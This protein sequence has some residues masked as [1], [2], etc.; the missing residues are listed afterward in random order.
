MWQPE[1]TDAAKRSFAV[2][3][4]LINIAR[5][6]VVTCLLVLSSTAL[7]A[8]AE[9]TWQA[10]TQNVD[11][12]AYSNPSHYTVHVGCQSP[13]PPYNE[14]IIENIPYTVTNLTVNALPEGGTCYFVIT[15]TSLIP[16]TSQYSN[17][18]VKQFGELQP[19][20]PVTTTDITWQESEEPVMG[21]THIG[22]D[23]DSSQSTT[24]VSAGATLTFT[25]D[26]LIVALMHMNNDGVTVTGLAGFTQTDG[27]NSGSTGGAS[28]AIL[29]KIASSDNGDFTFTVSSTTRV[30]L[31]L[32][33]LR[34]AVAMEK[35]VAATTDGEE[36]GSSSTEGP[37]ITVA[38]NS[39]AF[40]WH[41]EDNTQNQQP[42]SNTD[43]SYTDGIEL[44]DQHQ[45]Y[46]YRAFATGAATG[47]TKINHSGTQPHVG[48]S[49]SFKE[50]AGGGATE[51]HFLLTLGAGT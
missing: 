23:T 7:A 35:D 27:G 24:T 13:G 49:F 10:P 8:T 51:E 40:V 4:G 17:E 43:N 26:D 12:S 31:I 20:G 16:E 42:F 44:D 18:A 3:M 32:V 38:D 28:Y 46:S 1:G 25:D 6:V 36:T 41:L 14:Q 15:A 2:G 19:P 50:G 34:G 33:Q 5:F 29:T 39:M 37:D 9:L 21:V 48:Y 30:S 45:R 22:Q 47:V 11:G